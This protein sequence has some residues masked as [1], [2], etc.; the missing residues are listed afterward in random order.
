M[1]LLNPTVDQA[2][3]GS[4]MGAHLQRAHYTRVAPVDTPV[5]SATTGKLVLWHL[6]QVLP[7]DLCQ[8][9]YERLRT[10]N[11]IPKNRGTAVAGKGAMMP[12]LT[13][14]GTLSGRRRIHDNVLA[15]ARNPKSDFLGFY[16]YAGPDCRETEWTGAHPEVL[17]AAMPLINAV[18]KLFQS[19]LPTEYEAQMAEVEKV[20]SNL[21]LGTTA[22]TTMT[23]NK[24]F[25]TLCHRDKGDLHNGMGVMATLGK[26]TPGYKFIMP[27]YGIVADVQPGDLLLADVHLAHGNSPR[28]EGERVSLVMY[29]REKMR[30]CGKGAVL[31][32]APE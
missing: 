24:N 16:D 14:D 9:A 20:Q 18:D 6:K 3:A 5:Y 11:K 27:E 15:A 1:Q 30:L 10:V 31:V 8:Q 23:V 25:R 13:R 22:F 17:A 21:R 2:Q 4:L 29:C 7:A 32:P 28:G 26:W 19:A 12:G